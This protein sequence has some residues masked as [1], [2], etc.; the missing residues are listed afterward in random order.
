MR[1][2][3]GTANVD[4]TSAATVNRVAGRIDVAGT[5]NTTTSFATAT[6]GNN[7]RAATSTDGS[8]LW[9]AGAGNAN[10]GVWY[11]QTGATMNETHTVLT[12]DSVRC[13]AI[14]GDQLY[15]SS[16]DAPYL[17]KIG[18]GTPTGGQPGHAGGCP[19]CP[20]A[21]RT[22]T[23][24]FSSTRA[25]TSRGSTRCT[26]RTATQGLKKYT[27]NGTSWTAGPTLNIAG[28]AVGF[29]GVA[30]YAVGTTI[31]LMATTA[32]ATNRLVV[33]V[34]TGIGTPTGT[35]VATAAANTVFRGVAVS[36]HFPAP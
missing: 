23:R 3:P 1:T 2:P 21:A 26:S 15:G 12:P 9:L 18:F 36:P 10:G 31:T 32:E 22:P 17:F 8:E 16:G 34:D 14:F 33:F 4:G 5:V 25:R 7:V 35:A 11:N 27:F 28:N 20:P 30:G 6:S 24:S 13:L 29:R 19:A